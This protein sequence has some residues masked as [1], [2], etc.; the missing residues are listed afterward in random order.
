[1]VCKDARLRLLD[2]ALLAKDLRQRGRHLERLSA[3]VGAPDP[4][5]LSLSRKQAYSQSVRFLKKLRNRWEARRREHEQK[6]A[7]ELAAEARGE[8]HTLGEHKET[9]R[10]V[11]PREGT[12]VP[13]P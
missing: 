11:N 2:D 9:L 12:R 8:S 13:R 4:G 1:M 7:E 6:E 3:V 10:E 5:A